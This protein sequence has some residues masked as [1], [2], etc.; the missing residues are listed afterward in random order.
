LAVV[1]STISLTVP[2]RRLVPDIFDSIP[3]DAM[4]NPEESNLTLAFEPHSAKMRL[5]TDLCTAQ[6]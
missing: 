4:T 2:G 1:S 6:R 3:S 5:R